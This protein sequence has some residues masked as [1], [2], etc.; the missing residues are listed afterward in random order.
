[1]SAI[2]D[3]N[4]SRLMSRRP[5]LKDLAKAAGVGLATVDRV[6]NGRDNVRQATVRRVLIAAQEIGYPTARLAEINDR[7]ERPV[8]RF[9]FVLH[10]PSQAFYRSFAAAL[11]AAVAERQDVRGRCEIRFSA[12]QSPGD[13]AAEL[14]EAGQ[15]AQVLATSAINHPGLSRAIAALQGAGKPVF[16]LLNDAAS[17]IQQS[18]L[19]LDNVKVGRIAGWMI[20]TQVRDPGKVAVFIGGNRWHGH[21]L[22]E[23]GL[24]SY[25]RDHAPGLELLDAVVNLET[26]QVTYEATLDLLDRHPDLRGIYVAGGGMEGAIAAL[27][28]LRPPGKVAL[29]VNELTDDSRA[30]LADRYASLVIATPLTE[31]SRQLV[32]LMIEATRQSA[33]PV[34]AQHFLT[35]QLYGPESI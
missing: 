33:P 13:F 30:A 7:T 6:L 21:I 1:M 19:G 4:S 32:D 16:S 10:K 15:S 22:R 17:G 25:L 9:G 5:T 11:E 31:L 3:A 12:S 26:R 35:P 29:V 20:A 18:Y 14:Q 2:H 8:V 24:R 34:S 27:R 23:T 28:E